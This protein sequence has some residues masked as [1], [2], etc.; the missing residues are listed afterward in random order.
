MHR[1]AFLIHKDTFKRFILSEWSTYHCLF[2]CII[3]NFRLTC[4]FLAKNTIVDILSTFYVRKRRYLPNYWS[5]EGLQVAHAVNLACQDLSAPNKFARKGKQL[6][7]LFSFSSHT[8]S[9]N[10]SQAT[11]CF[12]PSFFIQNIYSIFL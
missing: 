1:V 10:F 11:L 3:L 4:G 7:P 8:Q 6:A 12:K 2:I 5:D 9:L